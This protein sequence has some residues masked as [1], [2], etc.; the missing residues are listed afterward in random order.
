MLCKCGCGN[1]APVAT[2]SRG[3]DR[4]KGPQKYVKG[5]ATRNK[6]IGNSY[7]LP[8]LS[9][10]DVDWLAGIYEGEGSV[11]FR[12]KQGRY[13]QSTYVN[14]QLSSTDKGT[15][16]RLHAL[17]PG[18]TKC[19]ERRK[20]NRKVVYRWS[21]SKTDLARKFLSL[22]H[23]YLSVRRQNQ[24]DRALLSQTHRQA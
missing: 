22:I 1:E 21:I 18:S 16:D 15:V 8:E 24:I 5:H 2:K 6:R 3:P 4:P 9:E 23:P 14:V 17:I 11:G 13:G 10:F 7:E 19:V 20:E 12:P